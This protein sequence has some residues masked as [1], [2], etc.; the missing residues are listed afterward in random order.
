MGNFSS[1]AQQQE[2]EQEQ[3]GEREVSSHLAPLRLVIIS[4]THNDHRSLDPLPTGDVLIHAGDFTCFGRQEHAEDF[5]AWLGEQPHRH[6]IVVNGNH[7]NNAPWQSRARALLSNAV[8]L[9]NEAVQIPRLRLDGAPCTLQDEEEGEGALTVFGTDFFWPMQAG[10]HNPHYDSIPSA[11]QVLVTHGPVQGFVDGGSGCPAM[12]AKCEE[13]AGGGGDGDGHTCGRRL[14]LVVSGH[15]HSA[16]GVTQGDGLG[17][18]HGSIRLR[19]VQFVNAASVGGTDGS[20]KVANP[21]IVID[22]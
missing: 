1:S 15:V 14:Q 16:Y 21:P 19:G 12:R 9:K 10:H 20:R 3:Q 8:F 13:L 17:V 2:Q 22:V 7:E 5:N 6:K 4:D 18:G 11:V